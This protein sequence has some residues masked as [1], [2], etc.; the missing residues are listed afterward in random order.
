MKTEKFQDGILLFRNTVDPRTSQGVGLLTAQCSPK[1]AV[2]PQ[3]PQLHIYG[4]NQP[5]IV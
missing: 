2:G 1:Y 4:F 3:Y 5:R